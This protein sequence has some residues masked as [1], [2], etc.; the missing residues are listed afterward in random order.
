M[1]ISGPL[2]KWFREYLSDRKHFVSVSGMASSSLPVHSGVP[3]GSILGPL[4]FLVYVND[5][6]STICNSAIYLFANDTKF[7]KPICDFNEQ[8]EL[9]QDVDCLLWCSKWNMSLHHGRCTVVRYSLSVQ[10]NPVYF[11]NDMLCKPTSQQHGS[12]G[13]TN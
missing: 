4:L 12:W 6:P 1:G 11:L 13:S 7:I 5:I 3:Q 8:D 9:Q 10:N 2:W